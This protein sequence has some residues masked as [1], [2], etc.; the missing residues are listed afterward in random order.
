MKF[1]KQIFIILIVFF[2]TETVFSSNNTFNVNNI[3]LEKKEKITNNTLANR[4]IKKGF[5]QLISRILLKEDINKLADLNFSSIKTL[6]TYYQV[7][8]VP[9]DEQKKEKVIFNITFDKDKI[10]NLFYKKGI[11]YS[12]IAD[13][14][15]YILPIFIKNNE[16]FIFN[17]NYFYK[18]WNEVSKSELID[19]ILP[20]EN[21][22]IIQKINKKK[23]NLL[24]LNIN[25]LFKEY[26][27]KNKAVIFI[28][29]SKF[30]KKKIYIKTFIQKKNISKNVIIENIDLEEEDSLKKIITKTKE[31]LVDLVKLENMIDIRTPSFLNVKFNL[32]KKSNLVKLNSKIKNVDIIEKVYVQEFNKDYM[33]LRIKYLGKLE[34]IINQLKIQ[35]ID[36]KL[37]NDQWIIRAL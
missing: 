19:Y 2:K 35:N 22:E 1:Y 33:K 9:D 21:I 30:T 13:K 18:N 6:V 7:A 23:D 27:N 29:H 25:D 26:P 4:A 36:L 28:E 5:D 32:D 15:L 16:I 3:E 10:H 17:N 11:L 34:K 12:E 14:D 31:E 8:D 20:L 24:D 37:K